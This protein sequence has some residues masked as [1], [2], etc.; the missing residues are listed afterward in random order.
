MLIYSARVLVACDFHIVLTIDPLRS[1]QS[2]LVSSSPL[3]LSAGHIK[4][5]CQCAGT[6]NAPGMNEL[7]LRSRVLSSDP[8]TTTSNS[9][10]TL[11]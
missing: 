7:L 9:G 4:L 5:G 3:P 6:L 1:K 8:L 2:R 11:K 10:R